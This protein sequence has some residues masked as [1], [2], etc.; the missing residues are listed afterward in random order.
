MDFD[1][2]PNLNIG[3]LGAIFENI[4][5]FLV[6]YFFFLPHFDVICASVQF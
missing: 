6:Y 4:L 5:L 1:E 3:L 2:F